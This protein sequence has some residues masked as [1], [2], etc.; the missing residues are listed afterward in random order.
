MNFDSK[1]EKFL[2][3]PEADT[4]LSRQYRSGFVMPEK[5]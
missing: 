4:M 5:V 1:E 2:N 3:D